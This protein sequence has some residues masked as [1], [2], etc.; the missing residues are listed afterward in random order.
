MQRLA[1]LT[2]PPTVG[3]TYAVPC[4]HARGVPV[5]VLGPPHADP[6]FAP[7]LGRHLHYDPR[8]LDLAIVRIAA[9]GLTPEQ[10]AL[11]I[12][13]KTPEPD[14]ERV[15]EVPMVCLRAMPPWPTGAAGADAAPWV[16]QLARDHAGC[17]VLA[18][19]RCPHAGTDGRSFPR[20]RDGAWTCIHGLR[21]AAGG[22]LDS[23]IDVD[24]SG[25]LGGRTTQPAA[26]AALPQPPPRRPAGTA[27]SGARGRR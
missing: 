18:D 1:C 14:D 19:G 23:V 13:H 2:A 5:P 3:Q 20:G 21:W 11:V 10:V 24:A 6:S 12:A 26:P 7:A 27:G 16:P 25:D 9:E 15:A 8:F 4:V 22:E 17:R